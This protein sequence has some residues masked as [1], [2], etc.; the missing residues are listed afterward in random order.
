MYGVWQLS[1]VSQLSSSSIEVGLVSPYTE[2]QIPGSA[3]CLAQVKVYSYLSQV[4]S[5]IRTHQIMCTEKK[6]IN[7]TAAIQK[8]SSLH[9][10]KTGGIYSSIASALKRPCSSHKS[11]QHA[12]TDPVKKEGGGRA[13]HVPLPQ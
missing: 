2:V 4:T 9:F 13:T 6:L 1:R 12:V 8:N 7:L 3:D 5:C 10:K 11:R